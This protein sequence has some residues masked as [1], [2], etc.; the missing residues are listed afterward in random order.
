MFHFFRKQQQLGSTIA[1]K[2]FSLE[3]IEHRWTASNINLIKDLGFD[4]PVKYF[5]LLTSKIEHFAKCSIEGEEILDF[6]PLDEE[7]FK[8]TSKIA[9]FLSITIGV[10]TSGSHVVIALAGPPS[11]VLFID[12]DGSGNQI[13]FITSYDNFFSS[14][15]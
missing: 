2:S 15:S 9:G 14:L 4:L 10:F 3:S 6:W 8:H 11:K 5:D 1:P 12:N 13:Y 7:N